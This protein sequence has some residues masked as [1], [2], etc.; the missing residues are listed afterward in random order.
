MPAWTM[1]AAALWRSETPLRTATPAPRSN[2]V[3]PALGKSTDTL[4]TLIDR[5]DASLQETKRVPW[6]L[7]RSWSA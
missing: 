6:A 1:P 5:A 7:V 3:S 4:E 2:S